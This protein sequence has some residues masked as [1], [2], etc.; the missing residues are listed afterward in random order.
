MAG[1]RKKLSRRKAAKRAERK[2]ADKIR[3]YANSHSASEADIGMFKDA[4]GYGRLCNTMLASDLRI[5]RKSAKFLGRALERLRSENQNLSFQF[6]TLVHERGNTSDRDPIVDQKFVRSLTDK[7]IRSY[8]LDGIYVIESQGIGNFP[9]N[10]KGRTI[11][12]HGHVITWS[13]DPPDIAKVERELNEDSAWHS[14]LGA[15]SVRVKMIGDAQGELDYMAYYLFKPPY[16]VKM[17]EAR[18]I[19]DR[20]KSTEKGYKPEFAAR[21]LELLTQLDIRVLVRGVGGG[22][23]VRKEWQ[24]QLTYWHRSREKWAE[25]NL[26]A[27]YFDD[28]WDRYR[29]KKKKRA[30]SRYAIIR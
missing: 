17:V 26:P 2:F 9:R 12:T 14:G 7:T 21:L 28:F 20:L 18:A 5:R 13:A 1:N 10:G 8:G 3:D 15:D 23:F 29:T 25:G 30:Y 11:M 4:L 24:R 19:G 6:W 27:Y 22:K 16:D